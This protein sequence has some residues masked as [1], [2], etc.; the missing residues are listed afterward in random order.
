MP[1]STLC[2]IFMINCTQSHFVSQ[3]Q[4][5]VLKLMKL[6]KI[7]SLAKPCRKRPEGNGHKIVLLFMRP[8]NTMVFFEEYFT[9]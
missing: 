3:L 8:S 7:F 6:T 9:M 4:L 5:C 1:L 2:E